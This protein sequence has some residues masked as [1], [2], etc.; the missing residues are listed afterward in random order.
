M[1]LHC[2]WLVNKRLTGLY[3]GRRGKKAELPIPARGPKEKSQGEKVGHQTGKGSGEEGPQ[4]R[5]R[6]RKTVTVSL[7]GR[8]RRQGSSPQGHTWS[9]AR[10]DKTQT[11]SSTGPVA[12]VWIAHK[13]RIA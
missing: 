4:S 7:G 10:L 13:V 3:L 11:V 2:L 5:W 6:K 1:L 12:V 9:R 8:S